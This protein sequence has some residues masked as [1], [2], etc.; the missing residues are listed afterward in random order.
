[1]GQYNKYIEVQKSNYQYTCMCVNGEDEWKVSWAFNLLI[2]LLFIL[3]YVLKQLMWK[4]CSW[5]HVKVS[6]YVHISTEATVAPIV[7]FKEQITE[8]SILCWILVR[9]RWKP[10]ECDLPRFPRFDL[11][12]IFCVIWNVEIGME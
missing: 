1:M 11:E 12:E 6:I 5:L 10:F 4:T 8:G 9:Y 2:K 3:Q 7:L